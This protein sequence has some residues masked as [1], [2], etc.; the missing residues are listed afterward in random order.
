MF[1]ETIFEFLCFVIFEA[2]FTVIGGVIVTPLPLFG[3][4]GS[5]SPMIVLMTSP[6]TLSFIS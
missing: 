1:T 5:A 6:E 2:S 3:K 4:V